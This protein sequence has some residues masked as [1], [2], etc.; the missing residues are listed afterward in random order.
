MLEEVQRNKTKV[1]D[2]IKR[3]FKKLAKSN[4]IISRDQW[5]T[6]AIKC[7]NKQ[8]FECCRAIVRENLNHQIESLVE[9]HSEVE[10]KQKETRKI[11][12]ENSQS[13]LQ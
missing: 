3:A 9:A 7:E 1:Y 2:L 10:M 5:L 13:A 8:C 12:I 4:I 6:E 11:W